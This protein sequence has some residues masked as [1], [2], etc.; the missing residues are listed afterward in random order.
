MN[1]KATKRRVAVPKSLAPHFQE[2][3]LRKLNVQ[4]DALV[5]MQRVLEYGDLAELRWLFET[6]GRSAINEFVRQR[7]ESWLSR[8]AFYFWRRYFKLQSW[9]RA[10]NH[11]LREQLWPF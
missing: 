5:I 10:P 11:H 9:K 7:D 8:R 4:R 1:T 6:Y 2:F 3:S